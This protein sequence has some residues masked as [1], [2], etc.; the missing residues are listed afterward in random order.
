[1]MRPAPFVALAALAAAC[2]TTVV[3]CR[4]N[5]S[6]ASPPGF[7]I[8]PADLT[9]HV[10]RRPRLS[11]LLSDASRTHLEELERAVAADVRL[12]DSAGTV[13]PLRAQARPLVDEATVETFGAPRMTQLDFTLTT[14]MAL[15]D[16]AYQ[17][18]VGPAVARQPIGQRVAHA[19]DDGRL[20]ARFWV[21]GD[22]VVRD[23]QFC[24]NVTD[25]PYGPYTVLVFSE[26]MSLAPGKTLAD[27]VKVT[28]LT[29]G[30]TVPCAGTAEAAGAVQ[31]GAYSDHWLL[32]CEAEPAHVRLDVTEAVVNEVGQPVRRVG[33][34]Q[35]GFTQDYV[36]AGLVDSCFV[37]PKP[38]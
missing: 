6:C 11:V 15:A 9:T 36:L 30:A 29:T 25:R 12:T 8:S 22:A 16:G 18:A 28:D 10:G 27:G 24:H 23:V 14:P 3:N 20:G 37:V 33:A 34:P 35:P 31:P 13:F 26:P 2:D 5:G 1:M 7:S 38:G 17:L 4:Q 32:R 21:G 19:F